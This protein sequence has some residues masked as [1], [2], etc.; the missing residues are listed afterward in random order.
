MKKAVEFSE[1]VELEKE[2][3]EKTQR[4]SELADVDAAVEKAILEESRKDA[5]P[6]P[7]DEVFLE[8][9]LTQAILLQS[10]RELEDQILA[11]SR[12][13]Y[14]DEMFLSYQKSKEKPEK[15]PKPNQPSNSKDEDRHNGKEERS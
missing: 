3:L 1:N 11:A 8:D 9:E 10:Q 12:K 4:D 5:P 14:Y 6:F 15:P 7:Q 2:I 13:Q